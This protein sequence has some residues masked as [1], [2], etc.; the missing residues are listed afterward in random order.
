METVDL[1]NKVQQQINTADE[2]LLKMIKAL[3]E[4]YKEDEPQP[5]LSE[6]DYQMIDK[7]RQAHLAG[8]SKSLTWEEV[9]SNAR[10]ASK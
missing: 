8:E 4:T 2:K 3:V 7:R 5:A 9:K 1:R 10:E 6:E